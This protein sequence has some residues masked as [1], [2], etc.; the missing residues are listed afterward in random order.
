MGAPIAPM[1]G[2]FVLAAKTGSIGMSN[3][4]RV[5]NGA[6]NWLKTKST[7]TNNLKV[8]ITSNEGF[9]F[10]EV[11]LQFGYAAN[12][13]GAAKLFSRMATA[14]SAYLYDAKKDLSVRY[15][16]TIT[17]NTSI[18]INFRAGNDGNYYL[19]IGVE[20][21]VYDILTLED[22]KTKKIIDLKINPKY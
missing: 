20:S 2:Y 5:N 18:P 21:A 10:D 15:L 4:I 1:Q 22:K 17:E 6:S 13:P 16:T 14:P 12:Q 19:S 11:L 9:G 8:R 3:D 7:K